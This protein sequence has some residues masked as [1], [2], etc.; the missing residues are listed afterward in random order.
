RPGTI[1]GLAWTADSRD[2]I[3][4]YGRPGVGRLWRVPASGAANPQ[5]LAYGS[6]AG[7]PSIARRGDRMAFMRSAGEIDIWSLPLSEGG[8][9][10]GPAV[11]AFDS[12]K[13][14]FG[15]SF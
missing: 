5:Q 15:P 12:S 11:R 2:V 1:S 4:A 6:G 8:D 3:F 10:N 13:S 7:T 14:E 9:A